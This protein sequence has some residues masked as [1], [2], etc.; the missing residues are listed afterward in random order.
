MLPFGTTWMNRES[1]V[2]GEVSQAEQ[3]S[4]RMTSRIRGTLKRKE[5]A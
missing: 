3:E 1:L 2:L 4:Y 5:N